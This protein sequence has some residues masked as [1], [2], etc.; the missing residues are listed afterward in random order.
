M[1]DG[2]IQK[3]IN[4]YQHNENCLCPTCI[5]LR[6]VRRELIEE[7]RNYELLCEKDNNRPTLYVMKYS[8]IG[9]NQ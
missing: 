2:I 5:S 4:T 8:L 9:D 6:I 7:I 3:I 1:T